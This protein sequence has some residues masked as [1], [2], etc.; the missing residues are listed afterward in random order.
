M[1]SA[2]RGFTLIELLVVIGIIVLLATF[3]LPVF[4]RVH[5]Q[6]SRAG[7]AADLEII[8]QALEAYKADFGDYPRLDRHQAKNLPVPPSAAGPGNPGGNP[9]NL[10][11]GADGWKVMSYRLGDANYNGVIDNGEVPVTTGPYLLWAAGPDQI[12]GN[13]DDVMCDGAQLQQITG[14]LPFQI[15]PP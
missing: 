9:N 8:S 11:R 14:S 5:I 13:D 6:S 15:T 10:T 1:R 2:S 4:K 7:T 3:L 12:F